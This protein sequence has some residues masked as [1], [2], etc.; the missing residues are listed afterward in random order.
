MISKIVKKYYFFHLKASYG[1]Y[2]EILNQVPF[3]TKKIQL[4]FDPESVSIPDP[5]QV[6]DPEPDPGLFRIQSLF[7][8]SGACSGSG[9]GAGS[10]TLIFLS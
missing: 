9:S 5:E 8:G 7:S 2:D 6:Q 4:L 1:Y 10:R 3:I